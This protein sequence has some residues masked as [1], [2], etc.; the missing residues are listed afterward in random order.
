MFAIVSDT[1]WHSTLGARRRSGC[2]AGLKDPLFIFFKKKKK[3]KL[4]FLN[5]QI[6]VDARR[7]E[8]VKMT[9]L[10]T[11]VERTDLLSV[12]QNLS[13]ILQFPAILMTWQR[14]L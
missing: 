13:R 12:L 7:S 6:S 4:F 3:Q 8:T 1:R 11:A 10:C 14:E 2:Q 9:V 5:H